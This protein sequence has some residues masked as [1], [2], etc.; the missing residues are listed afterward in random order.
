LKTFGIAA[1]VA[2]LA[3]A[4]GLSTQ[5]ATDTAHAEATDSVVLG[6]EFFFG[7]IDGDPDDVADGTD[8]TEACNG[9][10]ETDAANL[11]DGLGDE[12]GTLEVEDFDDIDLDDNQI[13]DDEGASSRGFT[14]MFVFVDDDE[15]VT[16]DAP[17]GLN[18]APVLADGTPTVAAQDYTCDLATED[19]DCDNTIDDDGDGVVVSTI[20]DGT[21]DAGD[22]LTVEAEQADEPDAEVSQE[23]LITG[24]ADEIT[25]EA[26]ETVVQTSGST[27]EFD[28][29][30]DDGEITDSDQLNEPNITFVKATVVDSDD[31]E[32]TRVAVVWDSE[33][34]DIADVESDSGEAGDEPNGDSGITVNSGVAGIGAFAV[35]CGGTETGVVAIT[36][37]INDGDPD[38]EDDS[39][40]ITVVGEPD[41][42]TLTASPAMI[43]CDGTATST[44]TATVVDS[45]GNNVA[46]GT[47]VNFS[48]VALGTANPINADTTDGTASSTITP[49]SA[50]TAG[51]TVIVTAG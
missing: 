18:Q 49:L 8:V 15:P 42:V 39:V 38:E 46:N 24:A 33:D 32:L 17:A 1:L 11:A 22:S 26:L 47:P 51:V 36:G 9:I 50:A 43:A 14:Y 48:V 2:L 27:S 35:V 21:A 30:L 5:R 28:D 25:V 40:D 20:V 7:A 45:E 29:C 44:V 12:D 41:A 13:E 34:A 10:D 23:I 37:T 31:T 16:F 6:C 3:I 4:F 19:L